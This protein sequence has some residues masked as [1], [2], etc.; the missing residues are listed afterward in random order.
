MYYSY[1]ELDP[2]RFPN[3]PKSAN[4]ADGAPEINHSLDPIGNDYYRDTECQQDGGGGYIKLHCRWLLSVKCSVSVSIVAPSGEEVGGDD[5]T[6]VEAL[7]SSP[8]TS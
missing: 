4:I 5:D 8:S 1:N 3:F 7:S 6:I 2:C